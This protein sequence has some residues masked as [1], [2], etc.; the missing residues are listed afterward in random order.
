MNQSPAASTICM[1]DDIST[2]ECSYTHILSTQTHIHNI[3]TS[4]CCIDTCTAEVW[5]HTYVRLFRHMQGYECRGQRPISSVVFQETLCLVGCLKVLETKS[6]YLVSR[7]LPSRLYWLGKAQES[8]CLRL[9]TTGI[10][11][12][13]HH[14]PH[15]CRN[16]RGQILSQL[17]MASI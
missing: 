8:Y 1:S 11:Y 16:V 6:G 3:S 17:C 13:Y 12:A 4:E 5:M 9:P 10:T 15:Y 7:S 14:T 2:S